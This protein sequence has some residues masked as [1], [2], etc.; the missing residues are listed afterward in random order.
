MREAFF[1]ILR[2]TASG[3]LKY[4]KSS[5]SGTSNAVTIVGD[6][7]YEAFADDKSTITVDNMAA[8]IL[9]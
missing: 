7:D 1:L 5:T 6:K 2:N 8:A 9:Q 3:A 4:P